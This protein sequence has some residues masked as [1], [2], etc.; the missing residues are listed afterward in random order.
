MAQTKTKTDA[1]ENG[2]GD[3]PLLS[4]S[5]ELKPCATVEIDGKIF[6]VLNSEHLGRAE[7]AKTLA[8]FREHDRYQVKLARS[9]NPVEGEKAASNMV[10][11]RTQIIATLTSIPKTLIE[12]LGMG[13]QAQLLEICAREMGFGD[14]GLAEGT[15]PDGEE[16]DSDFTD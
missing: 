15:S 1:T 7:E 6:S 10:E 9:K 4:L 11:A 3:S 16:G 2:S 5:T 13:P 12:S 8:L 14:N